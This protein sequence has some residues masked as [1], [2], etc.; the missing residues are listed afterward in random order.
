[1]TST[2]LV[3]GIDGFTGPYVAAD[4][5][6]Q[7]YAVHG[8]S[9]MGAPSSTRS[10]VD[11]LD[12]DALTQAVQRIDPDVVVHLAGIS[13]V[14][15]RDVSAIYQANIVGTRNL[16]EAI[17][18]LTK[19]PS[20]VVVASSAHVYG[21]S[22]SDILTERSPI[23]PFNDYAVSKVATEHLA[24]LYGD[25]LPITVTRPFNYTGIGQ[26]IAFFVPKLVDHARRRDPHLRLGNL[27]VE[28]D[29]TDVRDLARSYGLLIARGVHGE[30]VN[31]C[32]GSSVKLRSVIEIVS[33]LA[34]I[35]FEIESDANLIRTNEVNRL[36]GSN[37]HLQALTGGLAFRPLRESIRWM[38]QS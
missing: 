3:T 30:V 31:V 26:S 29:F 15:H 14:A 13:H 5:E 17:A 27:D 8:L 21:S 32:S 34:D 2:A 4:L 16:L 7:G 20:A 37:E 24:T 9:R 6:R 23:R 33:E 10:V 25:R 1:M 35:E 19:V 28:R 12:A 36:A 11:L 38:L 18:S 22:S